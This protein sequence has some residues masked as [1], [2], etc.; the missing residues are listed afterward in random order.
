MLTRW[1]NVS[2][3]QQRVR[4]KYLKQKDVDRILKPLRQ[5]KQRLDAKGDDATEEEKYLRFKLGNRL[6]LKPE[7][8]TNLI[9]NKAIL[10]GRP[11]AS[12]SR[13]ISSRRPRT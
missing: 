5:D 7:S 11:V 6:N 4:F 2:D 13:R 9:E 10:R 12:A 1:V 3:G 8:V